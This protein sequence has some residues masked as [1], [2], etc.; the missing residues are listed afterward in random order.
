M[1]RGRTL[2]DVND[3]SWD[4]AA[5]DLEAKYS[6]CGSFCFLLLSRFD[7][8][9]LDSICLGKRQAKL[10]IPAIWEHRTSYNG[11]FYGV[12]RGEKGTTVDLFQ[13]DERTH[14]NGLRDGSFRYSC[15]TKVKITALPSHLFSADL[16]LLVGK[17]ADDLV[18]VL[19]LPE[20]GSGPPEIKHLR[21]TMNQILAKLEEV[22]RTA[23]PNIRKRLQEGSY[24][25]SEEQS[26]VVE[27]EESNEVESEEVA[28]SAIEDGGDS[29]ESE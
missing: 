11:R 20:T 9:M 29:H 19:F 14:P 6:S 18:R 4:W 8:L 3:H 2:A 27:S 15:T 25:S 22:A 21:V 24:E 26:S 23:E 13:A 5:N 7:V 17:S 1:P 28:M 16:Y 10:Q 12:F